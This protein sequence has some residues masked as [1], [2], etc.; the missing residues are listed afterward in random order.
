MDRRKA[1]T[2]DLPSVDWNVLVTLPE[3][4]Y[5]EARQYLSR[6]GTI[7]RSPYFNVIT[8]KVDDTASFLREFEADVEKTPG[9]LNFVSHVMPAQATFDFVDLADFQ[10]QAREIAVGWLNRFAGSRLHVRLH[11]RGFKGVIS[12]P[13][14][15]RFL[16]EAIIA[17]LE[18]QGTPGSIDFEDPDTVIQIETIDGRVGMSMW[19]RDELRRCPF[20]GP[21]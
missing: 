8:L 6:F 3:A 12:T 13:K 14:E 4:T 7:R 11:R 17:A 15:E 10:K 16:D 5:R 9:L 20:L 21:A 2:R 18:K 19:T 1:K